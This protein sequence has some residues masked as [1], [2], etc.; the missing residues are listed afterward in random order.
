M[1]KF[2]SIYYTI[3]HYIWKL[4]PKY[5]NVAF[6]RPLFWKMIFDRITKGYDTSVT[7][8]LDYYTAKWI[9]PRLLL[10]YDKVRENRVCPCKYESIIAKEYID[11][12]YVYLTHKGRFADLNVE[13]A[14]HLQASEMFLEDI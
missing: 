5:R 7:W 11:A 12:G 4:T 3:C 2:E 6:Y 14:V 1:S 10:F 9:Y 13:K 8:S